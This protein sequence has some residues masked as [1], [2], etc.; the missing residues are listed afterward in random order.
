M[1]RPE[2][3]GG[4]TE[5]QGEVIAF[6]TSAAGHPGGS[7]VETV[8][9][10]GA[11]IFLAGDVA[12]KIKRAVRYDY[13]DLST[14]DRRVTMLRRELDLNKPV[15][16][17]IYRDVIAVTR[18]PD[19][20]LALGGDG[21]PVEWVLRM[22][23]F[24]AE[25]ELSVIADTKGID[26]TLADDLGTSVYAFHA[27]A[28]LR[29]CDGPRLML[30]I[31][32][33][34]DRAFVDIASALGEERT[35]E[36]H[37]GSRA[38][39][40]KVTSLLDRRARN[41]HV[42]RCHG[43]LHL[44]NLAL[45]DGRPVPFDALE[46]DEVLGTCDVLYDLAFLIMDLRHR[47]HLR[48]AN[49]ALN[50]YLL[51]A[52]GDEDNGLEALPLF[53][54]V[55]AAISAM[56]SVQTALATGAA[57]DRNGNRFL[58]DAIAALHPVAPTLMLVGGLSGT[59]KTTVAHALAPSIGPAPGAVH[60]RTDLE[61]QV[62]RRSAAQRHS[63]SDEYSQA[64][65]SAVYDRVFGRAGQIL[66]AGHAVLV[67]A[68]FL[69]A[70]TRDAAQQVARMAGVPYHGIWLEA[71]L[72][73]LIDRVQSRTRDA[74]DANESVVR[75]QAASRERP[76]G[77]LQVSAVGSPAETIALAQAALALSAN[78]NPT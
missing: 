48:A 49:M 40:E 15:A 77:W 4:K 74:S 34:L 59:G 41:G 36:F 46:F 63:S 2:Q 20:G 16:P 35:R 13:M 32:D 51:A 65:R 17:M 45:I 8:Q 21:T 47:G 5:E 52:G 78:V 3:V 75:R 58:E 18:L 30:D 76:D 61:R 14:L 1:I 64:S 70:A 50:A 27:Q 38:M 12:L 53:L 73:V 60:L 42:R 39:L 9:T 26:D 6:L 29:S 66:A 54:S 33:E 28:A 7:Q 19:G 22:W 62:M 71:P 44:R 67:D 31:L 43:D 24:P 11:F 25:N 72:P 23:R 56:V 10:H 68:T 37:A 55:R 69:D 57:L